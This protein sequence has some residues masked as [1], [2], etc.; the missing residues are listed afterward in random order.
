MRLLVAALPRPRMQRQLMLLRRPVIGGGIADARLAQRD[1]GKRR[2]ARRLVIDLCAAERGGERSCRRS[3]ASWIAA[4]S[5]T[6]AMGMGATSFPVKLSRHPEEPRACAASRRTAAVHRR[7]WPI[8][9][10]S[11]KTA[12][13]LR[14][15]VG[16]PLRARESD[17]ASLHPQLGVDR[18]K[19]AVVEVADRDDAIDAR[20]VDEA[21]LQCQRKIA[22]QDDAIS[23]PPRLRRQPRQHC[24]APRAASGVT[25][26]HTVASVV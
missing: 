9:R 19:A 25:A 24:A 12:M 3:S 16:R 26:A 13:R 4:R 14:M 15:T 18:D 7:L 21:M 11:P 22:A 5:A 17:E 20:A 2:I 1:I 23:R 8:L 10:G 6:G